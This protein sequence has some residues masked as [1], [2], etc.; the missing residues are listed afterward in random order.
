M[1]LKELKESVRRSLLRNSLDYAI[2]DVIATGHNLLRALDRKEW[3]RVQ[4][5]SVEFAGSYNNMIDELNKK[6]TPVDDE[7]IKLEE[8]IEV[9]KNNSQ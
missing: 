2:L 4:K 1:E 9:L 7:I 5:K 6:E 8:K 3:D